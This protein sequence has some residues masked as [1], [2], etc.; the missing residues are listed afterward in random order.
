MVG[1]E[2]GRLLQSLSDT[3]LPAPRTPAQLVK[4][5]TLVLSVK[6]VGKCLLASQLEYSVLKRVE[7]WLRA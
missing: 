7:P 3:S 5:I 6:R 1:Q 2:L 4:G